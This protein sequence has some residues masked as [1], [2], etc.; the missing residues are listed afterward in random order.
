[1]ENVRISIVIP[2]YN[3]KEFL[4]RCVQ[5]VVSQDFEGYEVVL[6][7][8]GSTDGSGKLCDTLSE[9]YKLV[10]VIHK[11]N[12]GVNY[13][14]RTGVR[15]AYGEWISFVDSDDLLEPKALQNLFSVSEGTDIVVGF[16]TKPPRPFTM[17]L[18]EARHAVITG[19]GIPPSP[20]AKLIK[21]ELLTDSVFDFP[22]KLCFGED[23]IMNIKLLFSTVK[24]PHFVFERVYNYVRHGSSVSHQRNKLIDY[25]QFFDECRSSIIPKEDLDRYMSDI[26][27][28]RLIGFCTLALSDT[29]TLAEKTHPFIK[30]TEVDIRRIGYQLNLREKIIMRS[31]SKKLIKLLGYILII[32]NGLLYRLRDYNII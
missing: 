21:K 24:A 30:R 18:G 26:L 27:W 17:T 5:S 32:K 15:K 10:R 13:A 2:V 16:S 4:E 19:K 20:F 22:P 3:T 9:R 14:R 8:D 31:H 11:G 1:M 25:E 28:I 23:M 7:D 12:E 29:S 6:V